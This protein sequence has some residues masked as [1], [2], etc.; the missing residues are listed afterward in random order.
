MPLS[1]L[2]QRVEGACRAIYGAFEGYWPSDSERARIAVA[3]LSAV[4]AA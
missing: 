2:E 1:E 4:G 3:L